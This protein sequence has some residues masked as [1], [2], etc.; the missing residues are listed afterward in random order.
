MF[1]PLFVLTGLFLTGIEL[2]G[3][4]HPRAPALSLAFHLGAHMC[5]HFV[6]SA[7]GKC[8][9]AW[10][11]PLFLE[12]CPCINSIQ[13]AVLGL[14]RPVLRHLTL[15]SYCSSFLQNPPLCIK[16]SLENILYAAHH[17]TLQDFVV[18]NVAHS[19]NG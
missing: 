6:C 4:G 8:G 14:H 10:F 3:L 18:S 12:H 15:L 17:L 7:P 1:T 2:Q 5:Y 19:K 9:R 13:K 16:T 11:T